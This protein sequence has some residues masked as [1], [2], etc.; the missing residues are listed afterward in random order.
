VDER[1]RRELAVTRKLYIVW[2]V[3]GALVAL[4]FCYLLFTMLRAREPAPVTIGQEGDFLPNSVTLKYVNADFTDPATKKDFATLSLE[5]VR[6]S[7]GDFT[8]FFA[9]STDPIFGGQTPRQCVV[10]WNPT[11]QLFVEPCEGAAWTREGKY[12]QG[13]VPRDLDQFPA[14]IVNGDLVIQLDLIMGGAQP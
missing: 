7:G 13:N 14:K 1:T 5:I 12:S 3:L 9:R 6:D 4:M 10:E 2:V 11:S 8:V